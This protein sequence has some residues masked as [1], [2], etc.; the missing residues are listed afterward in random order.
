MTWLESILL[1]TAI[2]ATIA[3][4]LAFAPGYADDDTLSIFG[5]SILPAAAECAPYRMR[6]DIS[7]RCHAHHQSCLCH[8]S[9]ANAQDLVV[10]R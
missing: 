2:T 6:Q 7:M 4:A 9:F 10:T 1:A 3:S 8:Q 5:A